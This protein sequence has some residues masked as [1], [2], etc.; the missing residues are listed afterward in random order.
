MKKIQLTLLL[1][2][3][4]FNLFSQTKL[5][6]TPPIEKI[7]F[8]TN[9]KQYLAGE[10]L[11]LSFEILNAKSHE[12]SNVSV[13]VY[14][15]LVSHNIVVQRWVVKNLR[16]KNSYTFTLPPDLFS[17]Y[18]QLRVYTKW[19][20][21][22]QF[23]HV[24][25]KNILILSSYYRNEI[26]QKSQPLK[27]K[28]ID[29]FAESGKA[30]YGKECRFLIEIKDEFG[31]Y[32]EASLQLVTDKNEVLRE[33]EI[34][35]NGIG[36]FSFVPQFNL[37]YFLV[38]E[39]KKVKLEIL[40]T[41]VILAA[42]YLPIQNQWRVVIQKSEELEKLFV[43]AHLRGNVFFQKELDANTA[44]TVFYIENDSFPKGIIN[45]AVI[46]DKNE[47]L[48][49]R[50]LS[51]SV[52]SLNAILDDAELEKPIMNTDNLY[53][54]NVEL[55]SNRNIL[56]NYQNIFGNKK[57][58]YENEF[59]ICFKGKVAGDLKKGKADKLKIS[60]V[61]NPLQD[62]LG[63][64]F[65]VT[66]TDKEGMFEFKDL[67]FYGENELKLKCVA[68]GSAY[69]F[70]I[71]EDL[72]PTFLSQT[73]KIDWSKFDDTKKQK[74]DSVYIE[75]LKESENKKSILLIETIVKAK[76]IE[77]DKNIKFKSE[78]SQVIYKDKIQRVNRFDDFFSQYINNRLTKYYLPK[79][80][81]YLD[82]NRVETSDQ[83]TMV[84]NSAIV[85]AEIHDGD[86]DANIENAN[87]LVL[88]YTDLSNNPKV[89]KYLEKLDEEKSYS[90][91]MNG[92][93][94]K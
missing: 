11:D 87:I 2:F 24:P 75:I 71:E 88:F 63:K 40:E 66:E 26:T 7:I 52:D 14:V 79:V 12:A 49:E 93:Y 21:N 61:V 82:D 72:T 81:Y 9:K 19:S 94:S 45:L 51:N 5:I 60:L 53:L 16:Q 54:K 89:L 46:N 70:K 36:Y 33:I 34:G 85:Y 3:L 44:S 76:K 32:T 42:D 27:V 69:N 92:Y 56:F 31:N 22:F 4:S 62:S 57:M 73:R 47:V 29:V 41:G 48:S 74:I 23:D 65:I 86:A 83:I 35:Q 59:G 1:I 90:F 8:D 25:T 68:K 55:I 50:V 84:Y 38:L 6:E 20:L 39:N 67:E 80:V 13:P 64:Q 17:D 15:E 10:N 37:Q 28:N 77:A 58:I 91:T 78:P 30:L 43:L 18:Y